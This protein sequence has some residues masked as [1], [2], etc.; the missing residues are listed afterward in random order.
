MR[1]VRRVDFHLGQGFFDGITV[2]GT[3]DAE[4]DNYIL[5]MD[6]GLVYIS[7]RNADPKKTEAGE[8]LKDFDC[9]IPFSIIHKVWFYTGELAEFH[10]TKR[11][12][13]K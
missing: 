7:A 10:S 13:A 9:A 12:K 1:D 4:K 5:K 3:V 11:T 8:K 6:D 2:R